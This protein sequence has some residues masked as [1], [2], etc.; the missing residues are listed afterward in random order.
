MYNTEHILWGL[1][2]DRY[3]SG[4]GMSTV[5]IHCDLFAFINFGNHSC[6]VGQEVS[7]AFQV[8]LVDSMTV[9]SS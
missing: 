8:S 1:P 7:S 4:E 2:H 3:C 9:K 6:L 5:L